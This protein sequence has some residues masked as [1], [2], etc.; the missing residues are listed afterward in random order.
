MD[1]KEV[2]ERLEA[3][4][5][6]FVQLWFTDI[7]GN[8]KTVSASRELFGKILRDG[9]TFDGSSIR[10]F[11]RIEE[12]DMYLM[13]ELDTM[14]ILNLSERYKTAIFFCKVLNPDGS[15]YKDDPRFVLKHTLQ[16]AKEEGY[17]YYVGPE[18]EFFI[19]RSPKQI[20]Y[21]DFSG[22]FDYMPAEV[23]EVIIPEIVSI[24]ES[25]G[26]KVEYVHHEVSP[27]QYE[28]D[29]RYADALTM[30]D[31]LMVVKLVIK[32]VARKYGYHATF[33][34]KPVE[35]INGS[36]MHVHQSLFRGD[37]NL[38]FD[39]SRPFFLSEIAEHFIAGLLKHAKEITVVTNQWVNSYKRLV[40]G[41]EAPVYISWGRYNRSPL[42]RVPAFRK[43]APSAAR[44]EYR[45]PD[46]ACNPYLAFAAML[47]A[48][49]AGIKGKYRL[50]P[51]TDDNIYRMSPED[52]R[53]RG[54][55]S[56]PGSLIEA[57]IEAEKGTI[58]KETFGASLFNKLMQAKRKEWDAYRTKITNY[59]IER[60]YPVL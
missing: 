5:I 54:I 36:G 44:V 22:Y 58:L 53:E 38:F 57:I 40:P 30:A 50:A 43:E 32:E 12:S 60:Y 21:L 2:L 15:H 55:E 39:E 47:A 49:M 16:K 20:D 56:L 4:G 23:G 13:P 11:A 27:S 48:G 34:P 52:R 9:A 24:L 3:E 51:P 59:E 31:N 6:G 29:L 14:K 17:E 1:E 18:V 41:Y 28:I 45:S 42:I 46:P 37:K 19:F 35:K 10:G 7:E 26:I 33:M 25:I 8:I